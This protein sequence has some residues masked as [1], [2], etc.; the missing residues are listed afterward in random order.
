VTSWNHLSHLFKM[1]SR[2]RASGTLTAVDRLKLQRA[3][4]ADRSSTPIPR[5]ASPFD[6]S[7]QYG[8]HAARA[9]LL[10]LIERET[11]WLHAHQQRWRKPWLDEFMTHVSLLGT[12][13]FFL[14][15]LPTLFWFPQS[16]TDARLQL[17][18]Q[19]LQAYGRTMV[20]L[21][22][23]GVY[24]TGFIKD[25]LA[26]PRPGKSVEKLSLTRSVTLEYGFPSTHS[27]NAVSIALATMYFA[28]YSWLPLGF[29]SVS[30]AY[31]LSG[32]VLLQAVL[33][34]YSRIYCGMHSITDVV[35]GVLTGVVLNVWWCGH[36]QLWYESFLLGNSSFRLSTFSSL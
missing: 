11:P 13:T 6:G 31:I 28:W 27:A 15:F 14:S 24:V 5:T 22:C 4:G 23:L 34:C 35:G 8:V 36:A 16:S 33:V 2:K 20:V 18:A 32:I 7:K 9:Y 12:H 25:L 29:L 10:D 19:S 26:L 17:L 1:A 30:G 21:L 3:N